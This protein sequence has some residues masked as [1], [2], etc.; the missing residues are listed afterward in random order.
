V[1]QVRHELNLLGRCVQGLAKTVA[2]SDELLIH[3]LQ[4]LDVF[5]IQSPC[6]TAYLIFQGLLNDFVTFKH[7]SKL[8]IVF[9]VFDLF[10]EYGE[11]CED[12]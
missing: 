3:D 10:V 4:C 12:N 9:F 1:H 11:L 5:L 6:K 7:L 8:F 2:E